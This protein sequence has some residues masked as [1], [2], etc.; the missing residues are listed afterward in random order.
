MQDL[1]LFALTQY[2][3]SEIPGKSHNPEILKYFS[4]IGHIWVKDDETAW[5]SAFVNWCCRKMRYEYSGKLNAR[6]WL[7]VGRTLEKPVP[8][9]IAVF[10][11]NSPDAATGHVGFFVRESK[12]HVWVLGGNQGNM[13]KI[14]AYPKSELLNYRM[15]KKQ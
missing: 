5:C 2:G 8:G 9:C 7:I 4:E 1:L 12:D 14:T 10:W 6:S 15:L 11:R 13:V 3:V